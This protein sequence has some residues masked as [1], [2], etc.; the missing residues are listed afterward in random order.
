MP[1]SL[2]AYGFR[3]FFLGAG[4]AAL[5]HVPWWA[6]SVALGWSLS[7]AW[8]PMLWHGHEMLFG[9]IAAAIAGFLLTAVPSWTGHRGFAGAPLVA[10][11]ALW[12]L[13]RL[14]IL[15]SQH[16]PFWLIA[17]LDLAF[18][19]TLAVMVAV[20]LF[21][22]K[23]RNAP[24][25]AVLSALWAC[26]VAFYWG[27]RHDDAPFAGHAVKIGIDIVLVLVTIIGG[28]IVPAFTA[29]GLKQAGHSVSLRAWPFVMPIVISLMALNALADAFVPD[30]PLVA[31]IAA[32]AALAQGVRLAQWRPLHTRGQPIVWILHVAY[33]WLAVGL[34]LKAA[35]LLGHLAI[36]AF[37]LHALTIGAITSMILAVMTRAALGHTG[38]PLV[39]SPLISAA[40][41]LVSAAAIVRVFAL[42]VL[43][44]GYPAIILASG[45]V[46]AVAF[47]LYV[48]VYAPILCSPR[49]DGRAG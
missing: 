22:S 40:Y 9:F 29:A 41:L 15:S 10:I 34:A 30:S 38:R 36:S 49:V 26:N 47:A 8:P 23:N 14:A 42:S 3:P 21:R 19:P 44:V 20:P 11:V 43:G 35:A 33:A 25:L 5:I 13:A 17:T 46:W 45:F 7:T 39:V 16:W 18:L 6:A 48:G 24:L 12:L 4:L 32:A 2:F 27:L 28:R 37:W 31:G 1:P